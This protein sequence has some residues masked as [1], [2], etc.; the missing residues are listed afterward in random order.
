LGGRRIVH[1]HEQNERIDVGRSLLAGR[2]VRNVG[3][4]SHDIGVPLSLLAPAVVVG[5]L[6]LSGLQQAATKGSAVAALSVA[7]AFAAIGLLWI[8]AALRQLRLRPLVDTGTPVDV[9][10]LIAGC[11]EAGWNVIGSD[12]QGLIRAICPGSTEFTDKVVT[13]I[14][15][16]TSSFINVRN[17]SVGK[18]VRVPLDFGGRARA[19]AI[20]ETML[21]RARPPNPRPEADRKQIMKGR[22]RRT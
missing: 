11:Y 5:F 13:V 14:I 4:W 10:K 19:E 2:L 12:G 1:L 16:E 22:K 8:L 20:L 9:R 6:L 21:P 7:S 18:G 15:T 3:A 17:R